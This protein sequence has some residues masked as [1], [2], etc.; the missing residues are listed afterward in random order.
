MDNFIKISV[1]DLVKLI[2]E[3]KDKPQEKPAVVWFDNAKE[4]IRKFA[5]AG[6]AI[7]LACALSKE[8]SEITFDTHAGSPLT[9]HRYLID[10]DK[11]REI[12]EEERRQF[13]APSCMFDDNG[14]LTSK[15]FIQADILGYIGK[16]GLNSVEFG[17]MVHERLG[18][19]VFLLFHL[20]HRRKMEADFSHYNEYLCSGDT[21]AN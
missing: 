2:K 16:N 4:E 19:P 12:T 21:K 7:G 17:E 6:D 10:G 1:A 11:V 18:V 9:D 13:I 5:Q 3:S 8:D 15:V 20:P 14:N